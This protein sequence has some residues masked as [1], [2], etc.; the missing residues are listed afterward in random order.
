MSQ[1]LKEKILSKK[2]V[3]SVIG[4]GYVGLPLAVRFAKRGFKVFGLESDKDRLSRSKAKDCYIDDVA[5]KDLI[6]VI[7]K[8]Q[9]IPTDDFSKIR[10]SDII[11]ICVPTPLRRKYTPD[12]SYILKAVR[13]IAKYQRKNSLVILESTTFPGTTDEF[14]RPILEK[15]G[16]RCGRDFLLAFSPERIDPGNK[17]FPV[18]KIPKIVGG[19][20]A[21]ATKVTALFYGSV[22]DKVV[23][24]SSAKVAETSKLLE[25][26]FRIVNIALVNEICKMAHKMDI[27]IWEVIEAAKTKP[28]GFMPFYPGPGCGGH[29]IP[30]DPL[31]LYWKAKRHGHASKF[32]KLASDMNSSMPGYIVSRLTE[33]LG[34]LK[35]KRILIIG[36]TYKKDVKDL[37]KSPVIDLIHE[38]LKEG[39]GVQYSD[40]IIPYLKFNGINLKSIKLNKDA[41]AKSS[42]AV[43]AT[44]HSGVDYGFIL[45]HSPLIFDTRN[46]FKNTKSKKVIKL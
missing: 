29:C 7:D 33:A 27:D 12:I 23:T 4:L 46:I 37:R 25:N 32:I 41:L 18:H 31:Y 35:R 17:E 3:I 1:K 43:I 38:L 26:T 44:N 36:V 45:K 28:F 13:I 30:D 42:C 22:L 21:E 9:L 14:M 10:E 11:V 24:V 19:V 8:K 40:P 15:K 5:D 20:T 2:V 16:L 6:S 34:N 39:A